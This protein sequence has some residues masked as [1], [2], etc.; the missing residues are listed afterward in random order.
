M[1]QHFSYFLSIMQ[2]AHV[3]Q[4]GLLDREEKVKGA[5]FDLLQTWLSQNCQ[6]DVLA[7]L[8]LLDVETHEDAAETVIASILDSQIN[9]VDYIPSLQTTGTLL[10]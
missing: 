6:D 5:S 2:R 10:L 8:K 7:L 3:L 9:V 1:N 4:K